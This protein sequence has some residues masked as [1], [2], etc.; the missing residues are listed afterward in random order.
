MDEVLLRIN[1]ELHDLWR[2]VDQNGVVFD[3]L[4]QDRRNATAAKHFFRNGH[5]AVTAMAMDAKALHRS[6]STPTLPGHD[7]AGF[8]EVGKKPVTRTIRPSGPYSAT[9]APGTIASPAASNS[10]QCAND[11]PWWNR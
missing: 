8:A 9:L 3:I 11:H 4:V 5:Q 7:Y 2:A 1:G 10:V 6:T